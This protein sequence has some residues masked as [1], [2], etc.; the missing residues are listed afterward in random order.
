M[1]KQ[2]SRNLRYEQHF[3]ASWQFALREGLHQEFLDYP[4]RLYAQGKRLKYNR[5]NRWIVS[6]QTSRYNPVGDHLLHP[7]LPQSK[8]KVP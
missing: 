7:Q 4:T 3:P 1:F 2:V 6:F 5:E 8:G